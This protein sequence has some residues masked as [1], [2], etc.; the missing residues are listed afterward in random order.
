MNVYLSLLVEFSKI[1]LFSVGGGLATL[2]FL[3]KLADNF[4]WFTREMLVDMIAISESTPGPIGVNMATYAGYTAGGV[5]GGIIATS[6]MIAPSVVIILVIT[7]ILD[8]FRTNKYVKAAFYGIR[9][10]VTALIA[11]AALGIINITLLNIPGYKVSGLLGDLVNYKGIV[12]FA[13]V[14]YL[15]KKFDKHPIYYIG[16][17]ALIGAVFRF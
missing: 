10:A 12:L 1:G 9:P 13:A 17:A 16:G 11:S 5:P 2:P 14:V 3:Y 8:R 4:D 15:L 7:R 6:A